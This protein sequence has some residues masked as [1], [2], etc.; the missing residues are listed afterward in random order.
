MCGTVQVFPTLGATVADD[1]NFEE[2]SPASPLEKGRHLIEG[3]QKEPCTFHK[4]R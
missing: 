3:L 2:N 1:N 4:Y